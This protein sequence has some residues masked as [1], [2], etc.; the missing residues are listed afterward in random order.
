MIHSKARSKDLKLQDC[1]LNST[2]T[3]WN[4]TNNEVGLTNNKSL[5][6]DEIRKDV[7]VF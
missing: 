4:V 6:T 3:I 5:I 2:Q 1:L 7:G